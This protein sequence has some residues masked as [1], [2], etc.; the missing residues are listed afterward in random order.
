MKLVIIRHGDPDYKNDSLTPKGEVEAALMAKWLKGQ[1]VDAVYSSPLG[2]AEKTCLAAQKEM[3][4]SFETLPWLREF[5]AKIFSPTKH[6]RTIPWDLMPSFFA[7]RPLLSDNKRWLEDPLF[8][9][10]DMKEQ[11]EIVKKGLEDLLAKHG[12]VRDGKIFR[13]VRRNRDVVVLFCHFGVLSVILSVLTEFSPYVFWQY[14]C[15]LPTSVTT[16]ATEEREEGICVFRCIGFGDVSHLALGGEEPS[17][18]ARFRETVD[19][20]ER[21]IVP[22]AKP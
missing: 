18:A 17:F 22:D 11:Y 20:D 16:L 3:G 13:P 14:F 4:F 10:T 1:K 19:S 15:A 21:V 12:Y 2:R 5:P 9:Y 6:K 8:S 7:K